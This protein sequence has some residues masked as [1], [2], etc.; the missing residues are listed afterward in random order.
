MTTK[1]RDHDDRED[2][3]TK[4][5]TTQHPSPLLRATAHRVDRTRDGN[6]EERGQQEHGDDD[7]NTGTLMRKRG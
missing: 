5:P 7:K 6:D 2:R 1:D 4:G 3:R